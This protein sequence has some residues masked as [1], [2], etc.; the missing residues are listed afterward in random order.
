MR[1][2]PSRSGVPGA[3]A[4]KVACRAASES[5]RSLATD[6]PRFRLRTAEHTRRAATVRRHSIAMTL[7]GPMTDTDDAQQIVD[8]VRSGYAFDGP[9]LDLGALV[10]AGQAHPQV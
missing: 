10:V 2:R 6:A 3:T 1:S 8:T 4:A 5:G 9:P 7:G